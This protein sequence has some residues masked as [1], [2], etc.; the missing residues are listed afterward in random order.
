MKKLIF[1]LFITLS[2][3]LAAQS[4]IKDII[5]GSLILFED[6]FGIG[7]VI[8]V[9]GQ[10]GTVESLN[11]RITQLRNTE[12]C[13]ITIPNSQIGIIQNLSKDWSQVDLSIKVAT[14]TD[15]T[16]ALTL[17]K[18]TAANLAADPDWQQMILEPPD[19][20][21]VETVDHMGI[22]LRL[23]LKTQPLKQWPVARELRRRLKEAFEE[24]NITIGV[25]T[26][27]LSLSWENNLVEN[28]QGKETAN[29]FLNIRAPRPD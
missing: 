22:S 15:L 2:I 17:L 7:D 28:H 9:E 21:G 6:Q 29:E 14:D 27:N 11:L 20:L 26:E 23:L 8:S 1:F 3:S 24:A 5:N 12:G 16:E 10:T 18:S 25:P 19:L 13:L 4:L